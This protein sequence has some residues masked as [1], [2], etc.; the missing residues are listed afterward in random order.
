MFRSSDARRRRSGFLTTGF[1]TASFFVPVFSCSV[2][3]SF[4][5]APSA[6]SLPPI[7]VTASRLTS[8]IAGASTSVTTAE[9]IARSPA[10]S[11]LEI[12]AQTPGVQLVSLFGGPG[13]ASTTVD[14]R[15]FGAFASAN[16]LVLV[17]GR[18]LNDLDQAGVD[19]S[20]IPRDSIAR[21]E[22]TR[23]NSGAVL[24]GDNAVASAF[25][26]GRFCAYPLAGR[27]FLV[28]A[29]ASF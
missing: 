18:R 16:T 13:G 22:I 29:G 11:L 9:D 26:P 19:F 1:L 21:I 28:K 23:G 2:A 25:A 5:Q 24:Y 4:A 12:I 7:H 8:G 3:T 14:L 15:G 10:Q 6:D 27:T 17:N 20:A